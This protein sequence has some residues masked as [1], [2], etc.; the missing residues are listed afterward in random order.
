M[1]KLFALLTLVAVFVFMGGLASAFDETDHTYVAANG[2]GQVIVWPL[3]GALDGGWQTDIN[4]IYTDSVNSTVVKIV[5]RSALY[6]QELLDFLVYLSPNDVWWGRL[7]YGASGPE[8][9]ST[10]DS[11]LYTVGAFASAAN[12][13]QQPLITASCAADTNQVGYVVGYQAWTG[14][15][16]GNTKP[17]IKTAYEAAVA[18]A[19]TLDILTGTLDF[20]LAAGGLLSS[21]EA[22]ALANYGSCQTAMLT[23]ATETYLGLDARNTIAEVEAALSRDLFALPYVS[24]D[25]DVTM[26]FWTGPTKYAYALSGGGGCNN[27]GFRGPFYTAKA[28]IAAPY[29][30]CIQYGLNAYDLSE[31]TTTPSTPIFSPTPP[32]SLNYWCN[33]LSWILF[34]ST[35]VFD[36]G[37]IRYSLTNTAFLA[38]Q[39]TAGGATTITY[40]KAPLIPSVLQLGSSGLSLTY[41]ASSL[42]TVGRLAPLPAIALPWYQTTDNYADN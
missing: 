37:W 39:A 27:D 14:A 12:P 30:G 1:K 10:D 35:F 2:K 31:N 41:G 9:Y 18:P 7:Q 36:E 3:Y 42:G 8:I 24:D 16:A 6:S 23:L 19:T 29:V 34:D 33:E 20:G 22:V 15:V 13:M 32:P 11:C 17:A 25:S 26:H 38:A 21:M 4:L 40:D 28:A 5:I